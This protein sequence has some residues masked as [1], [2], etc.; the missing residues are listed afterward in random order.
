MGCPMTS[1]EDDAGKNNFARR[2]LFAVSRR[3][4]MLIISIALFAG[5]GTA[6]PPPTPTV[7][8]TEP[9]TSTPIPPT[10]TPLPTNTPTATPRPTNTPVPTKTST[11]KPTKIVTVV[12][13]PTKIAPTDQPKP[14]T[15]SSGASA[16]M[17]EAIVLARNAVEDIGGELDH[18]IPYGFHAFPRRAKD[19]N[20]AKILNDHAVVS[21][22]FQM[23][24]GAASPQ[25]QAAYQLYQKAIDQYKT[26]VGS[27]ADLCSADENL[28]TLRG[29]EAFRIAIT[30]VGVTLTDAQNAL[31]Q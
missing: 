22:V 26:K 23:D 14:P 15:S 12:L 6:T 19:I 5:C 30:E 24:T 11:P 13:K 7:V 27:I 3:C 21:N 8:P 1:R 29:A 16:N 9:S 2:N 4:L 18:W 20:C 28:L 10:A 25:A 31:G 17:K